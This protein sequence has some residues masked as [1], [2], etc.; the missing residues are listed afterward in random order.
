MPELLTTVGV[1]PLHVIITVDDAGKLHIRGKA[2]EYQQ[3]LALRESAKAVLSSSAWKLV[4][5][6]VMYES[7][8]EGFLKAQTD[9]QLL[10]GQA[11]VWFGQKETEIL[12][13]LADYPGTSPLSGE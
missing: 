1:L 8:S 5:E 12:K 13:L 10:F 4:H 7:V 11:A 9:K 6:Q 3:S 2:L